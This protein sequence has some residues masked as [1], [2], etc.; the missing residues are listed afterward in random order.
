M[1][2]LAHAEAVC[3]SFSAASSIASFSALDIRTPSVTRALSGLGLGPRFL[4]FAMCHSVPW[5]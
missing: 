5:K 4:G 3:P 2:S 1:R